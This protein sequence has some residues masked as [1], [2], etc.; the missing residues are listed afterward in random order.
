MVSD[1]RWLFATGGSS[2]APLWSRWYEG[3]NPQEE[4]P[5]AMQRQVAIYR[6]KVIGQQ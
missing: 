5:E 1:P 6:E 4:P 2:Y 3:G